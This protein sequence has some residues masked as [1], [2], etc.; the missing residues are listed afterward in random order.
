MTPIGVL[1][2]QGDFALHV[3]SLKGAGASSRLV[4]NAGELHECRALIIPGGESTTLLKLLDKTGL[5][6]VLKQYAKHNP[7]MGTCAGLIILADR[8]INDNIEP[9]SLINL[10]VERNGYGRQVDSF[11]DTV[12]L[13][14]IS[15]KGQF[16]GIF[17]RAPRIIEV[18]HNCE[19]LGFYGKEIIMARNKNI[20]AATFHPELTGD[21]RV[22]RYFIDAFQSP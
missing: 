11:I 10:T 12:Q 15:G 7:I 6:P 9:L 5:R 3:K 1:A 4:R 21:H 22:H 13:P 16:E 17:I 8:V 14:C 2:L 20:L 19:P 18:G